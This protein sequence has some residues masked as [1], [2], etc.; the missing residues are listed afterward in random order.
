MAFNLSEVAPEIKFPS[1]YHWLWVAEEDVSVTLSP[2]QKSSEPPADIVGMAGNSFTVT[3]TVE[4]ASLTQPNSFSI[5]SLYVPEVVTV[6]IFEVTSV[7][8]GVILDPSYHLYAVAVSEELNTMVSPLQ[9]V[10]V[11]PTLH[12][13][14]GI[15]G[16]AFSVTV[17]LGVDV[18]EHPVAASVTLTL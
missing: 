3:V 15:F 11:S 13:I 17:K 16:R 5:S 2:G 1:K 12:S 6:N 14:V 4:A 18:A 8:I 7:L 10:V 9:N